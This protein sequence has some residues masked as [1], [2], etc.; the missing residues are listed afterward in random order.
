ME[1]C[2]QLHAP[3][4]VPSTKKALGTRWIGGWVGSRAGLDAA[5]EIKVPALAGSRTPVVQ[6]VA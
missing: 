2:G 5:E 4:A 1:V 6:P 3:A